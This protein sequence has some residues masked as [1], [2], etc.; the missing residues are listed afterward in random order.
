[1]SVGIPDVVSAL[2]ELMMLWCEVASKSV[3]R[4]KVTH[5]LCKAELSN[6]LYMLLAKRFVLK[7]WMANAIQCLGSAS[8]GRI[9]VNLV[10]GL[11][12]NYR[13]DIW[14]PAAKLKAFYKKHNLLPHDGS[15]MSLVA[16]HN[17]ALTEPSVWSCVEKA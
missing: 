16:V 15:V 10:H 9:I 6:S 14:L 1:M 11:V 17:T 8:D 13:L 5:S 12:E 3:I 7:S 2:L 4:S